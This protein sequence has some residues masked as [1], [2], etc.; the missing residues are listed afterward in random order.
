M[1]QDQLTYLARL[2]TG[3][4]FGF[5][6]EQVY[7]NMWVADGFDK[8]SMEEIEQGMIDFEL[9]QWR[10][11]AEVEMWKLRAELSEREFPDF[12]N[13]L[14]AV[15]A[16]IPSLPPKAAIAWEYATDTTRMSVAVLAVGQI[17]GQTAEQLD[18]IIKG[19]QNQKIEIE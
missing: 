11:T 7:D 15:N 12:E 1:T 8:P 4:W 17:L 6:G 3:Q 18:D 14:E 5:E 19:A 16:A 9:T 13:M 2:H 10:Q